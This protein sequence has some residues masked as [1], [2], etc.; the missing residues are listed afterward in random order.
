MP[1]LEFGF[2]LF[3]D[4]KETFQLSHSNFIDSFILDSI[5]DNGCGEAFCH[6]AYKA[7]V[8]QHKYFSITDVNSYSEKNPGNK[9]ADHLKSKG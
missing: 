4:E 3:N 8:D 1:K 2:A 6:G 9:F 7:I 5:S